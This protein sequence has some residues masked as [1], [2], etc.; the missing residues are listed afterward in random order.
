M[1]KERGKC[2]CFGNLTES[3]SFFLNEGS[4]YCCKW[5]LSIQSS[6]KAD[7][8]AG[9]PILIIE[10]WVSKIHSI[11]QEVLLLSS[12]KSFS[13]LLSIQT[14]LAVCLLPNCQRYSLKNY[15]TSLN[16][17]TQN[18]N[19]FPSLKIIPQGSYSYTPPVFLYFFISLSIHFST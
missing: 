15:V 11:I 18:L 6:V 17:S 9:V 3:T 8:E 19:D 16:Y 12:H 7:F 1:G 2:T 10:K 13:S 4:L 5:S 14:T